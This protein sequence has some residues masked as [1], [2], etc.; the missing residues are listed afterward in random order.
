MKNQSFVKFVKRFVS[1]V[2]K[3]DYVAQFDYFC[4][5]VEGAITMCE[6]NKLS[7]ICEVSHVTS[8]VSHGFVDVIC[9]L[10]KTKITPYY[11]HEK[12]EL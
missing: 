1:C 7:E 9:R 5:T 3:V 2:W 12:G 6:L 10:K 11:L 4:V 8:G